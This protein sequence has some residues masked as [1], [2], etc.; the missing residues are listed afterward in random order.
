M[1]TFTAFC[2]QADGRGTTWINNVKAKDLE[3]A[4][5]KAI[6]KC[7]FDWN[8]D[9]MDIVCIGIAAGDVHILFW[10]DDEDVHTFRNSGSIPRIRYP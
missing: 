2:Q 9:P 6:G 1:K 8:Y 7:S 3:D 10:E 5:H 4:K